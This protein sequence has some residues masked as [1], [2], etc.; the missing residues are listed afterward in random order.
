[1]LLS[2]PSSTTSTLLTFAF[3]FYLSLT[4]FVFVQAFR[5]QPNS[6]TCYTYTEDQGLYI[7][8]GRTKENFMLDLSVPWNT[9]DP[10]FRGLIGG[11]KVDE[12]A[13]AMTN[14]GGDLFVLTKGTGYVYNVR[15]SSWSVFHNTNFGTTGNGQAATTDPETGFI[16]IPTYGMNFQGER[17]LVSVDLKSNTVNTTAVGGDPNW[18]HLATWSAYLKSVV[19]MNQHY[20]PF[21]FTPSR[22]NMTSS[23]WG[24]LKLTKLGFAIAGAWNCGAAA[25]NGTK[26]FHLGA[27]LLN[28][29]D[30]FL[31]SVYI[32][33]V[34]KLTW[35]RGP[36]APFRLS[37]SAC[38]ISSDQFIVWGGGVPPP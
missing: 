7:L 31:T 36:T 28:P 20:P 2:S 12:G 3:I 8:G 34:V 25:Y 14:N 29:T 6:H 33:D 32:M 21:M 1:M 10:V 26:L 22:E 4:L 17:V 35:K 18:Y 23:T 16:Y 11:P 37:T 30:P 19:M 5:P 13:C 9:S 15:S 27:D 24:S 38:A